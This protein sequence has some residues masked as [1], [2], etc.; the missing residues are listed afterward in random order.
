[1]QPLLLLLIVLLP[2]GLHGLRL[3]LLLLLLLWSYLMGLQP[4]KNEVVWGRATST[5]TLSLRKR[6]GPTRSA[7][8]GEN[9]M[10]FGLAPPIRGGFQATY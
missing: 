6:L 10:G 4:M 2:Y 8:K 7:A 5:V 9:C 3:L 1:M